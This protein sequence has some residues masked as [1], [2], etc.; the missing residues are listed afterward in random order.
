MNF[1]VVQ[2]IFVYELMNQEVVNRIVSLTCGKYQV[3]DLR[4]G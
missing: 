2:Q 3:C 1:T 4:I